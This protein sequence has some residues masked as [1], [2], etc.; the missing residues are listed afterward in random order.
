VL[1]TPEERADNI[2]VTP[3]WF[4]QY[5]PNQRGSTHYYL[6]NDGDV[7]QCVP[8]S[9][10]AIANGFNPGPADLTYPFWA[11][12]FSLN[13]QTVSVEIEGYAHNIGSTITDAQFNSL[14]RLIKH[15]AAH[16]K[17]PLTRDYII[18]HYQVAYD[19][20]DPG[21]SFPWPRLMD[22][23]EDD[24]PLSDEDIRKI[25]DVVRVENTIQS[26]D[27]KGFINGRFLALIEWIKNNVAPKP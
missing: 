27:L 11:G 20:T 25:A 22:A 17:I 2:E 21:L 1:H 4:Q 15:R 7:Y 9:H 26:N 19:R 3:T 24:M 5:H 14:V 12:P 10:G 18:G 13:W 6:D 8:E 16:W 23:L